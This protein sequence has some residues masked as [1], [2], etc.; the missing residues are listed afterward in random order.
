MKGIAGPLFVSIGDEEKLSAFLQKNQYV[1]IGQAFV[2]DDLKNFSAY[3]AAGFGRFDEQKPEIAKQAKLSAPK[4]INW[5]NYATSIMQV[6]PI[7]KDRTFGGE[8]PEGVLRL[9]GTFVVKGDEIVYRWSDV[10]S[11]SKCICFAASRSSSCLISSQFM[12]FTASSWR[13]SGH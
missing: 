2:D 3:K 8:I 11:L 7:P 13:S 9:G 4:N 1:P 12:I 6:S 5:W 10:S